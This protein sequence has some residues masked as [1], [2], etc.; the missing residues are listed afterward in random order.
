MKTDLY[1]PS[2]VIFGSGISALWFANELKSRGISFILLDHGP[3]GG[4]QTLASQG[5]IHG[6][7]KYALQGA[8]TP[9]AKNVAEV[10]ELWDSALAGRYAPVNLSNVELLSPVHCLW[11]T[12]SLGSKLGSFFAGKVMSS[13][14]EKLKPEDYPEVFK[15]K[16]FKGELRAVD[17]KVLNSRSLVLNLLKPIEKSVGIYREDSLRFEMA[18]GK[19]TAALLESGDREIRPV[20]I[21]ARHFVFMAG[22]GNEKLSK[23]IKDLIAA[24][25][26][27]A[28]A[29]ATMS[30]QGNSAS[31]DFEFPSMQKRP[32]KMV[33]VRGRDLP[34]I[35]FVHAIG[36]NA[37]PLA[38]LTTH[39]TSTGETL[40]Y[41][42]GEIAEK[43]VDLSDREQCARA[44]TRMQGLLPWMDLKKFKWSSF[45]IDR[46]EMQVAGQKRPDGV[47]WKQVANVTIAWP[48]K[49]TLAPELSRQLL[50]RIPALEKKSVK[51]PD[52][53]QWLGK[54]LNV[55]DFPWETA[56][57]Q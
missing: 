17:E 34:R 24:E 35:G 30:A 51:N 55:R 47:T 26:L 38:T 36:A 46:A 56:H 9:A 3:L 39:T 20:R 37:L 15:H 2:V 16:K 54:D 48:T 12:Q 44:R 33:M 21:E 31:E 10:K 5:I 18:N 7:L 53:N 22:A 28:G 11:S 4:L 6:G 13:H 1:Q 41:I 27:I 57:A 40:W 50:E 49:L 29:N 45:H 8:L 32:L 23:Q 25:Q 14:A 42:G 52:H 19:I 43:G